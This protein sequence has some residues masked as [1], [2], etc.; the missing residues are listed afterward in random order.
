MEKKK[1][2]AVE[3]VE[4]VVAR[5]END[6]SKEEQR[7]K[8]AK[9]KLHKK[10]ERERYLSA[11]SR[12]KQRKK[13]ERQSLKR[14]KFLAKKE[15][16]ERR[17]K[18]RQKNR[19][20]GRSYGGWLAAVI[21]LGIAT[22]ILS[23]VLTYTFIMPTSEETSLEASYQRAFYDTVQEV[24][25]MDLN[26][27]KTLA[28][29]DNRAMQTYLV[30]LAVNSELAENNMQE[31]PLSDENKFYTTK[32]I[33]QIGD[34]SKYLNKKLINDQPITE[35]DVSSLKALYQMNLQ[36]KNTLAKMVEGLNDGF[37]F[38]EL[39]QDSRNNIVTD[40]LSQLE[41][42]SVEYPELIYDG[43]FS[44]GLSR[45]EIKGLK[46]E[47][48]T[49]EDAKQIFEVIFA[50][51]NPTDVTAS[52]KTLGAI[53]CYNVKGMVKD[54]E[55]YAQISVKGGKLV[56][57]S[58][59]GSCNDVNIDRE[60]AE[61]VAEEFLTRNKLYGMKAVWV[62]LA[63]NVYT[64]NYAYEDNGVIVYSDLVKVRVCAETAMVIGMEASSYYTNHTT[65]TIGSPAITTRI[66]K[67]YL[68]SGME[69]QSSRLAVVPVGNSS[70]RLCYEF[71]GEYDGS[72][73]YIYIEALNGRQI[74]MF[75]V[76]DGAEGAL[77]M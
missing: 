20:Q 54:D 60:Q 74:E 1:N 56:M 22:V 18:T 12:E 64:I 48:I 31:L 44:D 35:S 53:E 36:L 33:N 27:S 39:D 29:K 58:Y 26:L 59:A 68:V 75:K 67:G 57:F 5:T 9:Q 76:I 23:G 37:S 30:D 2:N 43:P 49:E 25:N 69:V 34:F 42:L 73:F 45:K 55:L 77:L 16:K 21:S 52:G 11:L 50:D 7:A 51:G 8:R 65:R 62:N 13:E 41:N 15:A 46:G 6:N 66:A 10:E 24:D 14:E 72:T 17:A 32:V 38:S 71:S 63:N 3:K 70:E 61:E 4:Q 47:E 40:N 19:E 28:T